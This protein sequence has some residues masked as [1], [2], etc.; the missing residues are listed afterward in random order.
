MYPDTLIA[1]KQ[2]IPKDRQLSSSLV[3]RHMK[4]DVLKTNP[5]SVFH[6]WSQVE[7]ASGLGLDLTKPLTF[8]LADCPELAVSLKPSP[9]T[10]S[11]LLKEVCRMGK[12]DAL[13]YMLD[14]SEYFRKIAAY[15][16]TYDSE[17]LALLDSSDLYYCVS[18]EYKALYAHAVI[19]GHVDILE[20]L[21]QTK[22]KSTPESIS[23]RAL[24][25]IAIR[26]REQLPGDSLGPILPV[27]KWLLRSI[28]GKLCADAT[29][30]AA[31]VG[32][33]ELLEWLNHP[34]QECEWHEQTA[35]HAARAP[36]AI[37]VLKYIRTC[38]LNG[39][40]ERVPVNARVFVSAPTH[41]M[42]W[43]RRPVLDDGSM[44]TPY[45]WC[46][47]IIRN[48]VTGENSLERIKWLRHPVLSDGS[49]DVPC[50][51]GDNGDV[52]M[53]LEVLVEWGDME[54]FTWILSEPDFPEFDPYIL[55]K[56]LMVYD[57]DLR[58]D[59]LLWLRHPERRDRFQWDERLTA[60]CCTS[61]VIDVENQ[62]SGTPL[63]LA[64]LRDSQREID[65]GGRCPW[66]DSAYEAA[67]HMLAD[68]Q[69]EEDAGGIC[70][71]S[72]R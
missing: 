57:S 30:Y 27:L 59:M 9:K 45:P 71:Q 37:E 35:E 22:S 31:R 24:I 61:E 47:S 66:G 44:C 13:R 10:A 70:P 2:Y 65:S 20:W 28:G 21:Y 40:E 58:F 7:W 33:I 42:Q 14:T 38:C 29:L 52:D 51:W 48:A 50:P 67:I 5:A 68:P 23:Q 54:T 3:C 32:D 69:R 43:A 25:Y 19:Y 1:I 8:L 34:D 41:V 53:L 63:M 18:F 56:H 46:P 60:L 15:C 36:N 64:W 49:V 72:Y 12:L 17:I 16:S 4:P 62:V 55:F 26:S 39:K 11:K 6:N